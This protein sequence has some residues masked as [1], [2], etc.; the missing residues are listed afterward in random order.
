MNRLQQTDHGCFEMGS[1]SLENPLVFPVC[2]TEKKFRFGYGL[3]SGEIN[4]FQFSFS[5]TKF[6][7]GPIRKPVR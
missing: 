1:W 4:L 6:H 7:T 3:G 2:R 5:S